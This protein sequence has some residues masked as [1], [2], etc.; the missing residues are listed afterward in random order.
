MSDFATVATPPSRPDAG[1][2]AKAK[3]VSAMRPLPARD[4]LMEFVSCAPGFSSEAAL[5]VDLLE[6]RM[7]LR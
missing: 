6:S 5:F 4:T 3:P 7:P 1:D 2:K